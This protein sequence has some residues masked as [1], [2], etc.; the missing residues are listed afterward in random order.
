MLRIWKRNMNNC[1]FVDSDIILDLLAKREPF[2]QAAAE[3]FTLADQHKIKL[4]TSSLAFANVFYILR[5]SIGLGKAK[6]VLRKLRIIVGILPVS[7]KS[8]DLALNSVFTDFGDGLQYYTAREH[9]ITLL[10]TRNVR[11][12][13]DTDVRA[14]SPELFLKHY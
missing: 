13:K 1:V 7:E 12:Y 2:Y 3:V 10:L 14:Y 5:K 8:V 11:D 4:V 6:E 9:D